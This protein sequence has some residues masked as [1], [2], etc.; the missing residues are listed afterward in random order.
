MLTPHQKKFLIKIQQAKKPRYFNLQK[1]KI[2]VNPEVFPPATD[3]KL[4]AKNLKK[5]SFK[6]SM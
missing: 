3:T 1:L 5:L 6:Q 2:K 4:L